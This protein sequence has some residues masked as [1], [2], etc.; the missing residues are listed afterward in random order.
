VIGGL[1]GALFEGG[2]NMKNYPKHTSKETRLS[3]YTLQKGE[4]RS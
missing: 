2:A 4:C 1:G 3:T